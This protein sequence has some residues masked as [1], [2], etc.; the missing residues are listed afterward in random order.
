VTSYWQ[1]FQ[2]R[3]NAINKVLEKSPAP[4]WA[5]PASVYIQYLFAFGLDTSKLVGIL[6]NAQVKQGKRLYGTPG[7]VVSPDSIENTIGTVVIN[8]GAHTPEMLRQFSAIN[9]NATLINAMEF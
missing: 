1:S 8:S 4:I 6:D 9:P 5:S 7:R 3:V 2:A